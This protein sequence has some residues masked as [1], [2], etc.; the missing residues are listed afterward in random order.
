MTLMYDCAARCQEMLDLKWQDFELEVPHPYVRLTGK[1]NKTRTVPLMDK[2]VEM[3]YLYAG[4]FHCGADLKGNSYVFYTVIHGKH[5]QMS[6]DTVASF[7]KKYGAEVQKP[8]P[9]YQTGF[10]PTNCGIHV[11]YIC[12]AA[13]SHWRFSLN[14]LGIPMWKP[15][16]YMLMPI[17]K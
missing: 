16:V 4:Y 11:P 12:T 6:P 3:L 17:Q 2:T 1:G 9:T 10:I 8:V 15:H 5:C 14:F 13:V 7:M